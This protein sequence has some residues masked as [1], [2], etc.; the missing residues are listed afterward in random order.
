MIPIVLHINLFLKINFA[1]DLIDDLKMNFNILQNLQ[2]R[3]IFGCNKRIF[4]VI[5]RSLQN[6]SSE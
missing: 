5:E 2:N 3:N 1:C 6:V 4:C